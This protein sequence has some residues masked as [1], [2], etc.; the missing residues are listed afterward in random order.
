MHS[1]KHENA[2][3]PVITIQIEN[4]RIRLLPGDSVE[5]TDLH[6]EIRTIT[7]GLS[8]REQKVLSEPCAECGV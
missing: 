2:N 6:K 8:E 5:L 7:Y 3:G 1:G 4:R